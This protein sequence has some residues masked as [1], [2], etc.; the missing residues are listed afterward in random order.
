MGFFD[1]LGVLG[2]I[3]ILLYFG[4]KWYDYYQ[5]NKPEQ[6]KESSRFLYNDDN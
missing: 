4:Y 5:K 6:I 3:L 1:A 2:V